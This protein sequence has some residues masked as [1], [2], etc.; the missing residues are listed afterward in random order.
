VFNDDLIDSDIE[1]K[2]RLVQLNDWQ[3]VII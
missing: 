1:L 3:Q 2:M